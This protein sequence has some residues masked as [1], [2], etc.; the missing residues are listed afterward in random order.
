MLHS[1][2]HHS[3][4]LRYTTSQTN[5]AYPFLSRKLA[6]IRFKNL[7][8]FFFFLVR[9]WVGEHLKWV[10]YWTN[11]FIDNEKNVLSLQVRKHH[12]IEKTHWFDEEKEDW[13]KNLW[14]MRNN[15]TQNVLETSQHYKDKVAKAFYER[16]LEESVAWGKSGNHHKETSFHLK[17]FPK[18]D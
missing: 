18:G 3:W 6:T 10:A 9:N 12:C 11:V 13:F 4:E 17:L 14:H 7:H 16:D 2:F 15:S 5:E 8:W 1:S